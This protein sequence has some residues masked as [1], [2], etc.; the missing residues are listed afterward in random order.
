M[1]FRRRSPPY[2]I[3]INVPLNQRNIEKCDRVAAANRAISWKSFES[4]A[5]FERVI[6]SLI[7]PAVKTSVYFPIRN[8]RSLINDDDGKRDRSGWRGVV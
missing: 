7:N 5:C 1:D 6:S 4:R 3:E 2:N 8:Q